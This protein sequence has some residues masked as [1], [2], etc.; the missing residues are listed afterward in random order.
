MHYKQVF[1]TIKSYSWKIL[2]IQTNIYQSCSR[3]HSIRIDRRSSIKQV[4]L[5]TNSPPKICSSWWSFSSFRHRS[6]KDCIH[7]QYADMTVSQKSSFPWHSRAGGKSLFHYYISAYFYPKER[8]ELYGLF[9]FVSD[10]TRI[11]WKMFI[12]CARA[13]FFCCA[14][15]CASHYFSRV[16]RK[17]GDTHR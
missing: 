9:A 13:T 1:R 4:K 3:P 17:F 5:H 12:F 6:S 15:T 16:S 10:A 2:K 7:I 11:G 8:R 14:G